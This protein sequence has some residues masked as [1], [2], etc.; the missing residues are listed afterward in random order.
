MKKPAL[1]ISTLVFVILI[2]FVA[3]ISVSNR[4]STTGIALAKIEDQV[5]SYKREN[6]ILQEKFLT[7]SSF[8]QIASRAGEIGFVPNRANFAIKTS[9]PV[10]IKQ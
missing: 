6:L 9:I 2:L 8:T 4:M 3:R 7:I 1:I 10:A 5:S